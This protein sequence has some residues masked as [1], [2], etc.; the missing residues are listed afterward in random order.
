M[1]YYLF[2]IKSTNEF[3][4]Y[5]QSKEI[6]TGFMK[7][8]KGIHTLEMKK[9][10]EDFFNKKAK[11]SLFKSHSEIFDYH[12]TYLLP[13]EED[14]IQVEC[15]TIYSQAYILFR[16]YARLEKFIK[17]T[18][19]EKKIMDDFDPFMHKIQMIMEADHYNNKDTLPQLF[20]VGSI[21]LTILK[22]MYTVKG[23]E[24]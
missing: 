2:F 1:T 22:R 16:Q 6:A 20:D 12:G 10:K 14:S 15:N 7:Q 17:Y 23:E 4:A 13:D 19:D 24:V 3:I 18:E 11:E 9:V 8:R 5:T 21:A